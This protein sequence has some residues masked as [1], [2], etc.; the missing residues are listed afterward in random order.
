[1]EGREF[2]R[3]WGC[4]E[5]E[6]EVGGDLLHSTAKE[7]LRVGAKGGVQVESEHSKLFIV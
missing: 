5:S 3:V 6:V 2:G 1:M 4:G 7:S